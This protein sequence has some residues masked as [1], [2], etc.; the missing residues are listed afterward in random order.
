MANSIPKY[1]KK[2][3]GLYLAVH[4]LVTNNLKQINVEGNE[5]KKCFECARDRIMR[6]IEPNR[7]EI[8]A[9]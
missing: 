6:Y 9:K 3:L 1:E 5:Q 2:I 8:I 4:W 7:K